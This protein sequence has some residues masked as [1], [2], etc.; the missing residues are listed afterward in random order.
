MK[1]SL[2][3]ANYSFPTAGKVLAFGGFLVQGVPP[4]YRHKWGEI[5]PYR[6]PYKKWVSLGLFHPEISVE[7][8][9]PTYSW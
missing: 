6:W 5:T 8:Y 4:T 7:L 2:G 1:A 9:N 3:Q